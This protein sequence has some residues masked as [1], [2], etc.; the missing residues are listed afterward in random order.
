MIPL[1]QAITQRTA[2]KPPLT[3]TV[4]TVTVGA[5]A[6]AAGGPTMTTTGRA[7]VVRD[8]GPG[9]QPGEVTQVYP[10]TLQGL[11][12]AL[13]DARF[14]SF[15]GV[16]QVLVVMTDGKSKVIRR[17]EDGHEAPLTALLGLITLRGQRCSLPAWL[18]TSSVN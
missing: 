5:G 9:T 3:C 16:P 11:T 2:L 10:Y 6:C 13:E 8:A 15:R 12:A 1:V 14:R 7:Y 4:A 18:R 17:F